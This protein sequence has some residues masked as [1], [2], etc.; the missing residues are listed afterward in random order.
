MIATTH[1]VAEA[2][3]RTMLSFLFLSNTMEKRNV[4]ITLPVMEK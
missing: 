3:T 1:E 2:N 4:P